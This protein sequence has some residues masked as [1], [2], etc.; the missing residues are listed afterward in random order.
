MS[1]Y[2]KYYLSELIQRSVRIYLTMRALIQGL[3]LVC[4]EGVSTHNVYQLFFVYLL[5]TTMY[6]IIGDGLQIASNYVFVGVEASYRFVAFTILLLP[7]PHQQR[8]F[9]SGHQKNHLYFAVIIS[10]GMHSLTYSCSGPDDDLREIE[11][12]LSIVLESNCT[13]HIIYKSLACSTP[14][15]AQEDIQNVDLQESDTSRGRQKQQEYINKVAFICI[16]SPEQQRE[17]GSCHSITS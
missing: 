11:T 9:R 4:G 8:G 6:N 14:T 12:A 7:P 3:L 5:K 15:K 2:Q 1:K 16:V 13:Y 17:P 10:L